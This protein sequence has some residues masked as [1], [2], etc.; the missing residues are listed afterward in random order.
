[1]IIAFNVSKATPD[2]KLELANVIIAD[3]LAFD[4]LED[5]LGNTYSIDFD[6][7]LEVQKQIIE[8]IKDS[9][10]FKIE[11]NVSDT[12][13]GEP[14]LTPRLE[15]LLRQNR[16]PYLVI[17]DEYYSRREQL[18]VPASAI[19]ISFDDTGEQRV[20]S[21]HIQKNEYTRNRYFPYVTEKKKTP[22]ETDLLESKVIENILVDGLV[23]HIAESYTSKM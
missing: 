4:F 19:F 18:K 13:A 5:Y 8:I 11:I 12:N 2:L 7:N 22:T 9:I 1:M 20:Y 16:I 17:T 10:D 23:S 14:P 15:E 3:D 6:D 21:S